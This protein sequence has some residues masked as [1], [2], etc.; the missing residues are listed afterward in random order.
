MAVPCPVPVPVTGGLC[1]PSSGLA[2]GMAG[3]LAGAGMG[4]M[5]DAVGSWVAGAA[6]WLLRQ[7]GAVLGSTTRI[8][9]GAPW[10]ATHAATMAALAGVVVLPMLLAGIIQAV[11][12]QQA[13]ALIRS[14]LVNL[15]LAMLLTAVAIQLVQLGLS[16]TD[17]LSA[18][19]AGHSAADTAQL[20]GPVS[21]AL[22]DTAVAGPG[23]PAFVLL[24]GSLLVVLGA[25]LLWVELLVREA[26]VYVAV[27]FLPLALAALVWP[28]VSHWARRLVDTLAALILAK[29]VIVAVLALAAGE[30]A[31]ARGFA[32]VLGGAALLLLAGFAPWSLFRLIPAL[33]AGAVSHLEGTGRQVARNATGPARSLAHAALGAAQVAGLGPGRAAG[34][35]AAGAAGAAGGGAAGATGAGGGAGGGSPSSG[36]PPAGSSGGPPAGSSGSVGAIGRFGTVPDAAATFDA[37]MA[38]PDPASPAPLPGAGG[39]TP[40]GGGVAAAASA[41]SPPSRPPVV[42]PR[43]SGSHQVHVMGADH[44]GPR[45]EVLPGP[46]GGDTPGAGRG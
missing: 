18:V 45:L 19:V 36:G 3:S 1:A 33:E 35:M 31:H 44:L 7:V 15:P 27:L 12:R 9:L 32:A 8:D 39:P 10:F 5:L 28:A 11:F 37:A 30:L 22:N 43:S 21:T 2:G 38:G 4:S 6:S 14:V 16:V 34:G 40:S 26:A 13:G 20:L 23:V 25:L 24:L 41:P 46:A 17:S 29:F 42:L